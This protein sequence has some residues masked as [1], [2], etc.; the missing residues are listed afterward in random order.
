MEI[1]SPVTPP[2]KIQYHIKAGTACVLVSES[3]R[4]RTALEPRAVSFSK[5]PKRL[6][7]RRGIGG[8]E[9]GGKERN[10]PLNAKPELQNGGD[11]CLTK[12]PEMK[13]VSRPLEASRQC[14]DDAQGR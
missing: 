13:D 14:F 8:V 1:H 5:R 2:S 6:F 7:E 3:G 9:A 11:V 10:Y 12:C 4:S